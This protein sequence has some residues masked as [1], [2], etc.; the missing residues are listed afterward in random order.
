MENRE[1]EKKVDLSYNISLM[2]PA[3][4]SKCFFRHDNFELCRPYTSQKRS[5]P[6]ACCR[7]PHARLQ[8]ESGLN[9]A[10]ELDGQRPEL[11]LP[12]SVDPSSVAIQ[13]NKQF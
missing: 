5:I 4:E 3:K 12:R 10:M 11:E 8:D 1:K 2:L 6:G 13:I 9:L 7:R